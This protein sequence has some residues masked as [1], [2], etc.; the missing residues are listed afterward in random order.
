MYIEPNTIIKVLKNCPLDN[1]YNHTIYFSSTSAQQTYFSGLTKYTFSNQTYQRVQK[2][3]IRLQRKAEDLYDCN[4]LMFQNSAF[5][6]KW[7]YAFIKSVE[8]VNNITSEIEFE[9]DVMQTWFFNYTLK[10]SFVERE[11]SATD[12]R[13]ANLVPENLEMGDYITNKMGGTGEFSP[14]GKIVIVSTFDADGDDYKGIQWGGMFSSLYFSVFDASYSGCQKASEFFSRNA[15]KVDGGVIACFW[16]PA[17]FAIET[18]GGTPK[19]VTITKSKQNTING[20]SPRNKKLLCYPYNMLYVTNNQGT[21]ANLHYEYFSGSSCN[22]E[23]GI[24]FSCNPTAL[25]VPL[26]YKGVDKNYDEMLKMGDFPQLA[27]SGDTFKAWLAQ[28]IGAQSITASTS[29][30]GGALAGSALPG[31]GTVVGATVG[32]ATSVLNTIKQAAITDAMPDQAR[33]GGGGY[34]LKTNFNAFDFQFYN[35]SIRAEFARQIDDYFDMF[36]YKTN[37]VKVPNTHSRPHWCF[38]K[39]VGCVVKG[40][41]PAD[42]MNKICKIYDNG[43]TFWKKGSEVGNYSLDNTV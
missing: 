43:I 5:G 24:D 10:E 41:V 12:V 11:H 23:M 22:F 35:K 2:G 20:Y 39:T 17:K 7:F 3:K 9:I 6:S 13:G 30:I 32:L 27:W 38:T 21:S 28:N 26:N 34:T 18:P 1:T 36:G 40:S 42:D 16:M 31:V 15:S 19:N 8:Y 25:L 14:V 33:S 37:R 29:V 4:Y